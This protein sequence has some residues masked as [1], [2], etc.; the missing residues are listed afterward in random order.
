MKVRIR[1]VQSFEVFDAASGRTLGEFTVDSKWEGMFKLR[2][3]SGHVLIVDRADGISRVFASLLGQDDDEVV[4]VIKA[5]PSIT[6]QI[7]EAQQP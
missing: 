6:A 5:S 2:S 4:D 3:S 7:T 1:P